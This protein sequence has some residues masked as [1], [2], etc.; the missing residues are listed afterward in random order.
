M[1]K[2]MVFN[3]I[4]LDGYFVDLKGDMGFANNPKPDAEWDA[5]V[6]GNA[7]GSGGIMVF[8]RITYDLMASFWPTPIA[9]HSN[10]VVAKRMNAT[11]K[12][13]FSRTMDKAA[14]SNTRLVKDDLPGEIRRL[15]KEDSAGLVIFGSGSIVS[16]LTQQALIDEYQF[17]VIP[18][19]LSKGRSMFAGIKKKL[20]LKLNQTRSFANGNVWLSYELIS[21]KE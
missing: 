8:G 4:S 10:P 20:P 6:N 5:F 13:V 11:R 14:W 19:V 3:S 1:G 15:K 12:V 16:Q 17:I 18:I 21:N 7:S 2:L 9:A